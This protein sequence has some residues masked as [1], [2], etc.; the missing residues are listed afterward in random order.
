VVQ[1]HYMSFL[2]TLKN[3]IIRPRFAFSVASPCS[4]CGAVGLTFKAV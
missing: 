3:G 2:R 1:A 4:P